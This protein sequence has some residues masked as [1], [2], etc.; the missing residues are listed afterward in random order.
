MGKADLDVSGAHAPMRARFS[1]PDAMVY[2]WAR[3]MEQLTSAPACNPV[4]Y[5]GIWKHNRCSHKGC[6]GHCA[7]RPYKNTTL[8]IYAC[9]K[10]GVPWR[11]EPACVLKHQVQYTTP[12]TMHDA[13]LTDVAT[14]GVLIGRLPLWHRRIYLEYLLGSGAKGGHEDVYRTMR[15]RWPR[16]RYRWSE[17]IIRRLVREARGMLSRKMKRAGLLAPPRVPDEEEHHG[18][19]WTSD[20]APNGVASRAD[21]RPVGESTE[22]RDQ[23][24]HTPRVAAGHQ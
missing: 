21:V 15:K 10:C 24:G 19:Q 16:A 13:R 23:P 18:S 22:D 5:D 7:E 14:A 4:A 1:G 6:A 20:R 3:R 11:V 8:I 9:S 2:A 17:W 12:P